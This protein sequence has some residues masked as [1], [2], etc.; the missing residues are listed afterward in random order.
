MTLASDVDHMPV[1][2]RMRRVL[3]DSVE[4]WMNHRAASKGAALAFYTLFS[5]A[6]VLVLMLAIVGALF[7]KQAAQGALFSQLKDLV[8]PT[9]AHT[10]QL[11]VA[12][13]YNP[14][15]GRLAT[16]MAFI[17]LLVGASSV[18]VELKDSLEDIWQVTK[19]ESSW[20]E[21]LRI[22]LISFALIMVLAGLLVASLLFSAALALLNKYWLGWWSNATI[23][24]APL[25][26]FFSFGVIASLFA[27][28]Y[29]M[30][31]EAHFSWRDVWMGAL[32]TAFL[33]T[34]GKY[35]IGLYLGRGGI[36][37][38]YGAAGSMIVL[39]LWVYYSAQIF[40]LG[41]IFTQQY[42]LWFGSLKSSNP[43]LIQVPLR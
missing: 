21:L 19:E 1:M 12:N 22:R 3:I 2:L 42:A 33:F 16:V 24:L 30:L 38:S 35:G 5:M 39:L 32:G 41:A 34:L 40:F 29:K 7:G 43:S 17:T 13:A 18:F 8:G 20:M 15:T 37:N 36:A 26:S 25:S 11:L 14:D 27:V 9:S 28:I 31:P 6:P 23:V 10:I 4:N